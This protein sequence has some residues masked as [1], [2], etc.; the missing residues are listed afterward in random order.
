MFL[1][2]NPIYVIGIK[3]CFSKAKKDFDEYPN[4]TQ[5]KKF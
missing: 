3:I 5:R 4:S 2:I 1:K